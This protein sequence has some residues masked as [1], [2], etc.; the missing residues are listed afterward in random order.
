MGFVGSSTISFPT[1]KLSLGKGTP[2]LAST[3][4]SRKGR[5]LQAK[6]P[7]MFISRRGRF[8]GAL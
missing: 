3:L 4:F 1:V 5:P 6:Y 7:I 8:F 2:F